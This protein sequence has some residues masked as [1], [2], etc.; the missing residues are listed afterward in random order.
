MDLIKNNSFS[1]IFVFP[2]PITTPE[3]LSG[4]V[5]LYF[6]DP[7]ILTSPPLAIPAWG[8]G[9]IDLVNNRNPS[10]ENKFITLVTMWRKQVDDFKAMQLLL[11]PLHKKSFTTYLSYPAT[12]NALKDAENLA[13]SSGMSLDSIA[14]VINIENASG[15]I[16]RHIMLEEFAENNNDLEGLYKYCDNLFH[17]ENLSHLLVKGYFLRLCMLNMIKKHEQRILLTNEKLGWFLSHLPVEPIVTGAKEIEKDVI[18]WELFRQI[19]SPRLDP[20]DEHRVDLIKE[21]VESRSDEI[22]RL[23]LKCLLLAEQFEETTD[24]K[25]L[26]EKVQKV[27]KF[28]VEREIAD[29]LKLDRQALDDFFIDL[30]GD[31]K[32]WMAMAA[33][34]AAAISGHTHVSTGAAIAALSS[35]GAK[36]FKQAANRKQ[37]LKTT[38]LALVYTIN[39]KL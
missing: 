12:V 7:L 21:L 1:G 3:M 11:K 17:K 24:L 16:I 38:D 22:G 27:I 34:I 9:L 31:E 32:T 5:F 36:A 8:L 15:E 25:Y 19:L 26:V 23:R 39:H 30:F 2:D 37:K 4:A 29:L 20:L 28:D 14:D 10:W 6:K 35:V 18:S 33:F 13:L